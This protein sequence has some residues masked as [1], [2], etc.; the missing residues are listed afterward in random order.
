M[1]FEPGRI[2][3]MSFERREHRWQPTVVRPNQRPGTLHIPGAVAESPW[4]VDGRTTP[5]PSADV[6][7]T[8]S[9]GQDYRFVSTMRRV[10]LQIRR[11][12][13]PGYRRRPLEPAQLARRSFL[14]SIPFPSARQ[15][16]ALP[17]DPQP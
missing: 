3:F 14:V 1:D 10:G 5:P 7:V 11:G 2:G 16:S 8:N 17:Q 4:A 13:P 9:L 6:L 12:S 15:T